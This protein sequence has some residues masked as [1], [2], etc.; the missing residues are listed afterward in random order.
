[1]AIK[2]SQ[3]F[4]RTGAF[5]VDDKFVLTRAEMLNMNDASM[6][7]KY[8]AVCKDDSKFYIYDKS[9]TPNSVT[10]KFSVTENTGQFGTIPSVNTKTDLLSLAGVTRGSIVYVKDEDTYYKLINDLP[11]YEASWDEW[12]NEAVNIIEMT[13]AEIDAL[14]A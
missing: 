8:F 11:T 2:I 5:P 1:M 4:L 9:A 12:G 3:E 10:G 13:E 6:P 14:F 7:D